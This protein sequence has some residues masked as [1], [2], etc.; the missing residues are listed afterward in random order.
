MGAKNGSH[1]G[2][3]PTRVMSRRGQQRMDLGPYLTP[4]PRPGAV[5]LWKRN[6]TGVHAKVASAADAPVQVCAAAWHNGHTKRA[7]VRIQDA[8][9]SLRGK[10]AGAGGAT[11]DENQKIQD[12]N[13]VVAGLL[14]GMKAMHQRNG[15]LTEDM[16]KL[17]AEIDAMK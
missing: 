9:K 17:Q 1:T 8:V 11:A 5:P 12:L 7:V 4:I 13:I 3:A 10:P 16:Q 15:Q 6:T 2:A 14:T